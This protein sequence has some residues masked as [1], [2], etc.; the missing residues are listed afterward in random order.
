MP[1]LLPRQ[2]LSINVAQAS[3]LTIEGRQIM[4]AIRKRAVSSLTEPHRIAVKPLGLEGDDQADMTVHG[5]LSKA[6]YAYPHEHYA[7]WQTVRAQASAQAWGEAMPHGM[8]GENL[9]LTGLLEGDVHVG[10]ILQF[11]DCSLAISEPRRPCYKFQ[12]VMGFPHA[13]KM[14]AQSGYCGFY[15]TV[16]QPGTIAAGESYELIPGPREVSIAELFKAKMHR[17]ID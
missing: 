9:T 6:V 7:F 11:S 2:L 15:L 13:V 4:T 5:G 8:L 14:M 16:R 3:P 17:H 10:D 1:S 12:A